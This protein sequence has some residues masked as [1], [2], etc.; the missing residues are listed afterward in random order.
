V[1]YRLRKFDRAFA[2]IARAKRI[3][4][5]ASGKSTAPSAS[6]T[7]KSTNKKPRPV[8]EIGPPPPPR[9]TA[10]LDAS[11][12]EGFLFRRPRD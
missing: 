2:D 3:E 12:E 4:K 6:S 10:N 11:R 5:T 7:E 9:R 1:F 8:V